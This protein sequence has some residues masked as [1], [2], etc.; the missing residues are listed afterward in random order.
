MHSY[1]VCVAI[2]FYMYGTC[3]KKL[4]FFR[5]TLQLASMVIAVKTGTKF[6]TAVLP[7]PQ[8]VCATCEVTV[9]VNQFRAL[10]EVQRH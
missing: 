9:N 7:S 3:Q 4:E 5:E 2:C 10:S 8:C 6:S 1:V